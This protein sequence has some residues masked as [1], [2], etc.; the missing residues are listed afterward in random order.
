[1][2]DGERETVTDKSW[3]VREMEEE[4]DRQQVGKKLGQDWDKE[5]KSI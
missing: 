5:T 4:K 3:K 2:K 1:M